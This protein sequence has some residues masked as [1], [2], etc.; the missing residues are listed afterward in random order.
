MGILSSLFTKRKS[1]VNLRPTGEPGQFR[2]RRRLDHPDAV[3]GEGLQTTVK[4]NRAKVR[5]DIRTLVR[6]HDR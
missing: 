3:I 6:I 1:N 2:L 4:K 5:G